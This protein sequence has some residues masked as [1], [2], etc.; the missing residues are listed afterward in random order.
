MASHSDHPPFSFRNVMKHAL[1]RT[2]SMLSKLLPQLHET[3]SA[4]QFQIITRFIHAMAPI[5]RRFDE[6]QHRTLPLYVVN[7]FQSHPRTI[8]S[9]SF[10]EMNLSLTFQ[11]AI[12]L[13]VTSQ[14]PSSRFLQIAEVMTVISFGVSFCGVFLRNSFPRFGNNLEKFGS[15][16]TSMIFFLMTTSFLPARIRWISWPVFALS[17]AAFLFSL[18]RWS[19]NR[20][21]L[22]T[23]FQN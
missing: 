2:R 8:R 22:L 14:I 18:F 16:L 3:N 20:S 4:N 9:T 23:I 5:R 10:G 15:V 1:S 11:V 19:E 12:G 21:K 17:M 13:L 7:E 6:P